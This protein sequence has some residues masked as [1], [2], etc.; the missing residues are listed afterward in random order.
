VA[1]KVPKDTHS[2][3]RDRLK[4]KYLSIGIDNLYNHEILELLLFYAI[5]RKDTNEIAHRILEKY[6]TISGVF[7]ASPK[8]LAL[9]SGVG[10]NAATLISLAGDILRV[11]QKD[12]IKGKPLLDTTEKAGEYIK[13]LFCGYNH[14]VFYAV[15]LNTRSKVISYEK[16]CEGTINELPVYPR[17]IVQAALRNNAYAVILAHNHPGGTLAPSGADVDLTRVITKALNSIEIKLRDHIIIAGE[18]F[19]SFMEMGL[20][21]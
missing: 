2:G 15:F 7:E 5:P 10:K 11:V 8:D 4:N 12:K 20:L 14:E 3:H 17:N 9:I 13:N 1:E 6:N 18:K 19:S 16:I 21:S